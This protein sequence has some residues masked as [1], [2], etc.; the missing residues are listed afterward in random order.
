MILFIKRLRMVFLK[1]SGVNTAKITYRFIDIKVSNTE[2]MWRSPRNITVETLSL[3]HWTAFTM[4]SFLTA[5][6]FQEIEFQGDIYIHARKISQVK[7]PE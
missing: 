1:V 4:V 3:P 2:I 6:S 7:E 5:F